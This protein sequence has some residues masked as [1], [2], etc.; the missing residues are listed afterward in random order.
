MYLDFV[1]D[2]C[3]KFLFDFFSIIIFFQDFLFLE[4]G[5]LAYLSLKLQVLLSY[6]YSRKYACRSTWYSR[7]VFSVCVCFVCVTLKLNELVSI[8]K[9]RHKNLIKRYNIINNNH[10]ENSSYS[11]CPKIS[12]RV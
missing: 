10:N 9:I 6:C 7:K 8:D 2:E 11:K 5:L 4:S 12:L 3:D 1:T